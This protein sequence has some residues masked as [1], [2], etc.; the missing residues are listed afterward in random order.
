MKI[1]LLGGD[2][3]SNETGRLYLLGNILKRRYEVEIVGLTSRDFGQDVWSPADTGE[4]NFK[5]IPCAY[6]YPDVLLAARK[7]LE[8]IEGDV[9]YVEGL[10]G[11][12]YGI[13][14]W[15]K[16]SQRKPIVL[17]TGDWELGWIDNRW[18]GFKALINQ[19]R[20]PNGH[21]VLIL[22]DKLAGLADAVTGSNQFVVK[23]YK[24]V[25]VPHGKD[26]EAFNPD[27]YDRKLLRQEWGID[28][29]KVLMF[30]G[31]IRQHKG[32]EEL[33]F[34][35]QSLGR[36]DVRLMLVGVSSED[37]VVKSLKNLDDGS[38]IFVGRR[39]FSD[40]PKFLSMADLVVIPQQETPVTR[41]QMPAKLYDAMAMAC[42]IVSTPVSDIPETLDG[43]GYLAQSG[44]PG[45]LAKVISEALD[46][47]DKAWELGRKA[48]Q[49]CIDRY[50]WDAIERTLVQVFEQFET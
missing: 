48:R 14:L 17:D 36:S 27:L 29:Y 5:P 21:P 19:F 20:H 33:M 38:T 50:S 30:L 10:R 40:V 37:P 6:R 42:P 49:R 43:C 26:T 16:L 28:Q 12:S 24:G 31:T 44:R 15:Y 25:L 18:Q 47:P 46:E 23:R 7:V 41:G 35:L 13:A 9:L 4:L 8:S 2:L 39:P 32:V 11:T 34:A 22:M 3:S 45:D 1:T